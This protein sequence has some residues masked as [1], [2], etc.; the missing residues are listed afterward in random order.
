MMQIKSNFHPIRFVFLSLCLTIVS[1]QISGCTEQNKKIIKLAHALDTSHPVHEAMEYMAEKIKEKSNG[2]IEVNIYPSQQ[3]GTEGQCLELLQIGV[4]GITKVS[5]AV[6]EGIVPEYKVLSFPYIFKNKE[7]YFRVLDGELGEELLAAGEEYWL[8]G[9]CYYDAGSRSFYSRDR[10]IEHPSDLAGMKIRVMQSNTAIQMIDYLGGSATPISWGELYTALQGGVVDAAENNP[11]S[12]YL[13]H[14][15]EVCKYY[16]LDEHA[17]IPDV[18]IIS[19]RLWEELNYTEKKWIKEAAV[20]SALYQR[21]LWEES[22]KHALEE[23]EKAGVKIIHPDKEPFMKKVE[24][25]YEKYK[26]DDEIYSLLSRIRN[27][28]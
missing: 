25:M 15:Y 14:H 1:L 2:Q 6:M 11:P 16:S 17:S 9:L 8:R 22:E 12:F 10:L 28:K 24:P 26:N 4:I 7:H 27:L 3:L 20:E 23:L 13:S 18:L 21:K 19:T 5:A